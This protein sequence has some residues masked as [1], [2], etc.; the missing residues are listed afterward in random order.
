M[1][2]RASI[3]IVDDD[4]PIR[5]LLEL[6]LGTEGY[7]V[8]LAA[9]GTEALRRIGQVAPGLILL[10]DAMPGL[11]GAAVLRALRARG[12]ATPVLLLSASDD[13]V[14]VAATC[15]ATACL[16]KP[17]DLDELLAAVASLATSPCAPLVLAGAAPA[18]LHEPPL[19]AG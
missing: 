3:L 14:A 15:G 11:S 13:A 7:S 10:D 4:A 17:F 18:M 19:A 2:T 16:A 9:D 12:W 5:Q 6:V 8:T 1:S